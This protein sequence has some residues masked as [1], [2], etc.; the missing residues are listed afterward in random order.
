MKESAVL[1]RLRRVCLQL[2]EVR[3]TVKWGHPT[4]EAGKRIFAVLDRYDG[5]PCIAFRA[6]LDRV[7]EL[8]ADERFTE[9][10]YAARFGWVC[11]NVDG[12]IDWAEVEWLVQGSYRL[13]AL[14]RMLAALDD[15]GAPVSDPSTIAARRKKKKSARA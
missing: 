1:A 2:P 7:D 13:V 15:R 4:F 8:L 11:L 14:K 12:P 9:A 6:P 3:E 5:R 10:P